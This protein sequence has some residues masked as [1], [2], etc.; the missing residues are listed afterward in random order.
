MKRFILFTL[1]LVLVVHN[2][3]AAS[4]TV[5]LYEDPQ[6]P[7]PRPRYLSEMARSTTAY[8]AN[9]SIY[10]DSAVLGLY[11]DS[12]T[13]TTTITIYD[14]YNQIIEQEITNATIT[15]EVYI[16]VYLWDSGYYTLTVS[17]GI[18]KQKTIFYI[19]E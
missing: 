1:L 19:P 7:D 10:L 9:L 15:P 3:A 18:T 8:E 5:Y 14:T 13:G 17:D 6:Y 4:A 11:L 16:P 2:I 12:F